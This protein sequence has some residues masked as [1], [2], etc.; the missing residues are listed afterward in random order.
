MARKIEKET[1]VTTSFNPSRVQED[2]LARVFEI[3]LPLT[4]CQIKSRETEF[5]CEDNFIQHSNGE[6]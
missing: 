3:L 2:L 4:K 1:K 6:S 5:S